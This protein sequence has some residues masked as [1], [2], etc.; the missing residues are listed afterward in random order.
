MLAR[1]FSANDPGFLGIMLPN[2]AG[3]VLA[4]IASLLSG[5]IPVLINYSTGAA[6]NCDFAQEK[7]GFK[8]IVTSKVL[9]A[10]IGCRPVDGMVF[11]EDL[12][13][14]ISPID[15]I[16]AALRAKLPTSILLRS[17]PRAAE[18][19]TMV[20]LFT[21]GS[22]KKPKAVPLTHRNIGANYESL[23]KAYAFNADDIFLANLP[24]FHSFGQ[25]ANLWAPLAAGAT[26]VTYANPLEHKIICNIIREEKIS[27]IA[28]T[29]TFLSGYLRNSAPGD[30]DSLRIIIT[31]ADKCPD[32][33][34]SGFLVKHQKVLFEAY[35]ATE[36]SPAISG[37][38]PENSRPGSVGRP[39]EGVQVRVEN[40]TTGRP[41]A[42][43][44]IGKIFVKGENVMR[45]YFRDDA[46]TAASFE[47]GWYDT[48]D[49]GYI[50]PDGYLWHVGRLKRFLKIGGEMIS[51]I[52]VEDVLERLLPP[53]TECCV[54][55]VPDADRGARIVAAVTRTLDE[56]LVL[57]EMAD[58]L[59]K[60][61]LPSRFVVLPELAKTGNGKTDFRRIT[62][63]VQETVNAA[64]ANQT[65]DF[66]MTPEEV[67]P[68]SRKRN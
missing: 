32:S 52:R 39:F 33:L 15:R 51:L 20:I 44:E 4:V 54:V 10:K 23:L 60:I 21:S 67:S 36:T 55:E 49:M 16:R 9:C 34:R 8:T 5:R 63:I 47:N 45:G 31:G 2:S 38:T 37:N 17:L 26:I 59:P 35:G 41:C 53:D 65:V 14:S 40:N 25:T 58:Q 18:D 61:A 57:K 46:Q 56:K 12:M 28:G 42:A 19:D 7:C 30:F 48:G 66:K 43:G 64:N 24:F 1:K 29:P 22:E 68:N 62:E 3:S 50:D 27:I 13:Q 6:A 11:L